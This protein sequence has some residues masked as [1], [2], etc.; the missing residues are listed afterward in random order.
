[1][2]TE[3]FPQRLTPEGSVMHWL[4]PIR[5]R[6]SSKIIA[7]LVVLSGVCLIAN[8][9]AQEGGAHPLFKVMSGISRTTPKR[10]RIL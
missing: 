1:M 3:A 4:C 7:G 5:I 10:Y 9:R 6:R 8:I 2:H